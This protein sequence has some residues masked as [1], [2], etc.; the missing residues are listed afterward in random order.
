VSIANMLD[1]SAN[2]RD[3][4]KTAGNA[5][6]G[7]ALM[8]LSPL[9]GFAAKSRPA[10]EISLGEWSLHRA[11]FSGQLKH[12]EVAKTI[13]QDFDIG[14]IEYSAQFFK[15]KVKDKQYLAELKQQTTDHGVKALLITVDNE[16]ILGDPDA[17]QRSLAV[18]N[19]RKWIEAA[20]VL[21]CESIRVNP[22]SDDKLPADEQARLLVDGLTQLVDVGAKAKINVIVENHGH[23]S[24]NG[25]WLADVVKKV[26]R[27]TCG[28]LPDFG[29][30][31]LDGGK[32][33]DRYKGVAELMPYA[34]GV[35]A[36]SY[37]FDARGNETTIDYRKMMKI[38][39]DAGYDGYLGVEYEGPR[40]SEPEGI[41]AT[42]NLIETIGNEL[43]ST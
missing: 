42:K 20:Q 27:P 23:M 1:I 28:T 9:R 25:A 36:K 17:K 3:F 10:F 21:G 43:L 4:L 26:N 41:R 33:Y 16:G 39:L 30:F 12:L 38:V 11:L 13:K 8:S 34:K 35:S 18:D 19:H 37:D 14:A 15:D 32:Q 7:G 29:N 6:A 31:H 24:S 40:L 22:Y 2:R 5:I